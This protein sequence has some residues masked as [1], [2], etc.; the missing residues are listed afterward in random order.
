MKKVLIVTCVAALAGFGLYRYGGLRGADTFADQAKESRIRE[1]QEAC[2]DKG[3]WKEYAQ[4]EEPTCMED[5]DLLIFE[6]ATAEE[7]EA[8]KQRCR[9]MSEYKARA[10]CEADCAD[11]FE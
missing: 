1:C 5:C 11:R 7:V 9:Q 10:Q 3:M 2:Q 6:G 8:C 4:K